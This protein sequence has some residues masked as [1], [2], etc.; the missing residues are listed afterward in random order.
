MILSVSPRVPSFQAHDFI[1]KP[2]ALVIPLIDKGAL[3]MNNIIIRIAFSIMCLNMCH[4]A[5]TGQTF[6]IPDVEYGDL[7]EVLDKQR[8]FVHADTLGARENILKEIAKTPRLELI[9]V[10][11]VEEAEFIILYGANLADISTGPLNNRA[12]ANRPV[13]ISG[14]MVVLR[15]VKS[16]KGIRPRILWFKTKGQTFYSIRLPL[17]YPPPAEFAPSSTNVKNAALKLIVPLV[18]GLL[19]KRQQTFLLNADT[20]EVMVR[21][22]RIKIETAATKDLIKALRQ[23]RAKRTRSLNSTRCISGYL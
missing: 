9:P 21:F 16:R 14:D 15:L 19:Q 17:N 5:A 20:N 8:V 10:G 11:R 2:S 13:S 12:E 4:L 7:S 22:R 6:Q 18:L 23:I 1:V 3:P